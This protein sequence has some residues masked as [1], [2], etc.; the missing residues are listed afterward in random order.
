MNNLSIKTKTL[1]IAIVPLVIACVL[2]SILFLWEHLQEITTSLHKRGQE[3][4]NLLAPASEYGVFSGN[5]AALNQ[6]AYS[7][8]IE[9]EIAFI[10]ITDKDHQVLANSNPNI[11]NKPQVAKSSF[12]TFSSPIYHTN[13]ALDDFA[14]QQGAIDASE[15]TSNLLLIGYVNVTMTD[16]FAAKRQQQVVFDGILITI[17][18]ILST[19]FLASYLARS[20]TGPIY[21]LT[22]AIRQ[23][24]HGHLDLTVQT[25]AGGELAMLETG[26]NDMSHALHEMQ[27]K[28]RQQN[29]D[30]LFFETVKAQT[31]L[32]SIGEGVISTDIEGRITYLNPAAEQLTGWSCQSAMGR[33]LNEVF[34]VRSSTTNVPIQY[35]LETCIHHGATVKHDALLILLRQDGKEYIIQDTASPIKDKQ[36]NVIGMVLVFHDVS[37]IQHMS[38]QLAYQAT[39]DDLTGLINRREFESCLNEALVETREHQTQHALC[40]IDLDQFK[41]IN[42]TC[43]H[44]A[45]DELLRQLTNRIK[46]KVRKGDIFARL[47]GDEF[48]IILSNCPM[49]K[50]EQIAT[51]IKNSVQTFEYTWHGHSFNTGTSIGLVPITGDTTSINELMMK[52]DSACYIA[53]D[54]GRNRVHVYQPNDEDIIKRAGD[55]QWLQTIKHSLEHNKFVLYRQEIRPIRADSGLPTHHEILVR[56]LDSNNKVIA[57]GVFIPAAELYQLMNNIDRWVI[58]NTFAN[59]Q[60]HHLGNDVLF[61]I[62]ISGQSVCDPSFLDFLLEQFETYRVSPHLITFEI[63]ETAAMSNMSRA[64]TFIE[65]IKDM[66]C[67]FALDDFGS[68]LSSFGYLSSLPV[69]YIKIDGY[70][71]SEL[72]NNPVNYS[73]IEAVNH[74]GHV[75]GLQTIAESVENE[76]IYK[77]LL[78]CGVDY[79]QGF[80]IERPQPLETLFSGAGKSNITRFPKNSGPR[81]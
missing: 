16:A 43:G 31:T 19:S 59:L 60:K 80:G 10:T 49:D 81:T 51:A 3:T 18:L 68:G 77:K 27:E 37:K 9:P 62:N 35:P 39:H 29:A 74:I 32:K 2:L 13:I 72:I 1:L 47:G 17:I 20:I 14:L 69:D 28:E 15:A 64:I 75:M 55:M 79:V 24:Q 73:I 21:K 8:A 63:T 76:A 38:D 56:M 71:A 23:I 45:G 66:G 7:A 33:R 42:D 54:N 61:N 65:T 11:K 52:A 4:A 57:P 41:I 40:Y 34:L 46:E 50:A 58:C 78:E 53:K 6:L 12:I 48:G 36:N 67:K 44:Q 25:D 70:F 22:G 5:L 30:E 26:I